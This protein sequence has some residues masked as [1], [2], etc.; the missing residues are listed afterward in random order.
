M[1]AASFRGLPCKR[2]WQKHIPSC[3]TLRHLSEGSP[4]P[5]RH[6]NYQYTE[7]NTQDVCSESRADTG[8]HLSCVS[9]RTN[10]VLLP[11]IRTAS[12]SVQSSFQ[13][14]LLPQGISGL[15][16][17]LIVLLAIKRRLELLY[18]HVTNVD[19]DTDYIAQWHYAEPPVRRIWRN[20]QDFLYMQRFLDPF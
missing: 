19:L 8:T 12:H 5:S 10:P 4:R 15:L 17:H 6:P 20:P 1:D 2:R 16:Y 3:R 11:Y 9:Q 18:R 7:H 13:G 14:S